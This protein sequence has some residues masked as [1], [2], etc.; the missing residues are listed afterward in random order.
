MTWLTTDPVL[1]GRELVTTGLAAA[2]S[3]GLYLRRGR[4][5]LASGVVGDAL[6]LAVLAV[7]LHRSRA[8]APRG[9]R[10]PRRHRRHTR[11]RAEVAASRVGTRCGGW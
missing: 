10:V 7:V 5:Y 8:R 11:R 1:D 6:G 3:T 2:V 9:R 4:P